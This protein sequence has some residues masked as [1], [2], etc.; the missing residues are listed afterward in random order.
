[1][2]PNDA[3]QGRIDFRTNLGDWNKI[4]EVIWFL[5]FLKFDRA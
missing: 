2:T 3:A 1:M 5:S 4:N